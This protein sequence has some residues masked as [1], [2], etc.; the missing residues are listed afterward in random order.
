MAKHS[1]CWNLISNLVKSQSRE[2]GEEMK[3]NRCSVYHDF[4]SILLPLSNKEHRA[5]MNR[6][7]RRKKDWIRTLIF[8]I[9]CRQKKEKTFFLLTYYCALSCIH[10]LLV[11]AFAYEADHFC[12]TILRHSSSSSFL[13]SRKVFYL[14]RRFVIS[15]SAWPP[16]TWYDAKEEKTA[17][18]G[19]N[20][21]PS[22]IPKR[23][24]C[25]SRLKNHLIR[26][27]FLMWRACVWMWNGTLRF[28]Y[29]F[30]FL[31]IY[32]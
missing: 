8:F 13:K 2:S 18:K 28:R 5:E 14:H 15:S 4:V 31:F 24:F 16:P 19:T 23:C 17:E 3:K 12:S 26:I 22:I 20:K 9:F 29:N 30:T 11:N 6:A 21:T 7:R 10:S 1:S 32:T 27:V 25:L